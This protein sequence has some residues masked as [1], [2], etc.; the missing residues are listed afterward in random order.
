MNG[1]S[2]WRETTRITN[3][4]AADLQY[5]LHIF[6]RKAVTQAVK[7]IRFEPGRVL[8]P[9][10]SALLRNTDREGVIATKSRMAE[11]CCQPR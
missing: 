7:G 11:Q 10:S 5:V 4:G 1:A 3:S 9:K 6:A 2:R 8:Q